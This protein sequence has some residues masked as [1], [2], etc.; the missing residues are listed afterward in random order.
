MVRIVAAVLSIWLLFISQAYADS[1]ELKKKKLKVTKKNADALP[2]IELRPSRGLAVE[3]EPKYRSKN[4]QRFMARFGPDG[5][6]SVAFAV[7]EKR[8]PGK[9]FDFLYTD[10]T[11]KGDLSAG[12][13]TPGKTSK[14]G[15]SYEDTDFKSLEIQIPGI[16]GPEPYLI[17]IRFSTRKDSPS[18]SSLF[19]T[20]L[21]ILEGSIS[22]GE[23]QLKMMVF[24]SNCNGVFGEGGRL[25]KGKVEGDRVW[26]GKGSPKPEDA[27]LEAIPLGKYFLYGSE[28]F[29]ITF[30]GGLNVDVA[31]A[32]VPL[33]T[34]KVNNPGFLLELVGDDGVLYVSSEKEQI[35]RVPEGSYRIN[36]AS[37]RRKYKGKIWELEGQQG[38]F[39]EKFSVKGDGVTEIDV[40]PPLKIK[41]SCNTR[42]VGNG[43]LASLSFSIGGSSSETYKYLMMGGKKVD[44][45]EI[46]IRDPK[47]KV[48]E[49]GHFEYG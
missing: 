3:N 40:G 7:D 11:G 19:L 27:F 33:G 28:Y 5:G 9:G 47:N 25:V 44:L 46:M 42:K 43:L 15:Y 29:E 18:E 41:I 31:K 6:V 48:V 16:N 4:P 22:L 13:K 39:N 21:C 26:L 14:R 36:N 2:E 49:E 24:D 10:V 30:S 38:S 20:P 17:N 32:D 34:I 23:Q 1:F 8:G 45:P 12:K 35:V 37:F